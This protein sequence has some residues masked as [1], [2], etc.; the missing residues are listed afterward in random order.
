FGTSFEDEEFDTVGGL[1]LKA[2]GR[3][4]KRGEA[5]ALGGLRFRVLRAD[6]RRLH[7]L[8]VERVAPPPREEAAA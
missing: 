5:I 4:P 6:S 1:V 3:L 2:F 7:T 8:Q